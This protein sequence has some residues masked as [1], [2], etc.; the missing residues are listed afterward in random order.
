[1]YKLTHISLL[2]TVTLLFLSVTACD[3]STPEG[4]TL[5]VRL[6]G[7]ASSLETAEVT[8]TSVSIGSI[9]NA[10]ARESF[11]KWPNMLN[12]SVTVDLTNLDG[13]V[14]MLL[15]S[16]QLPHGD[17]NQ[18]H[19]ELAEQAY[20]SYQDK[21][22]NAKENTLAITEEILGN[23]VI[24]FD[25]IEL[26][27]GNERAVLELQFNLDDSFVKGQTEA[28]QYSPAL[29]AKKLMVKGVERPLS[30]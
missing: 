24:E 15:S 5:D 30:N 26:E 4:G 9:Y 6:S 21:D 10:P 13:E 11:G 3:Y 25:P 19:V 1:M 23:V 12:D 7:T 2:A 28:Y 14:D 17:F 16:A 20:I 29:T 22:G 27:G 8:I 18:V